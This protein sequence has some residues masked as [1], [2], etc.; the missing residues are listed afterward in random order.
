MGDAYSHTCDQ[1][2]RQGLIDVSRVP[3]RKLMKP[4]D[5]VLDRAL[6]RLLQNVE[7]PFERFSA[8]GNTP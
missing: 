3:L 6:E 7:Q 8:F 4:G 2:D 5:A 1:D